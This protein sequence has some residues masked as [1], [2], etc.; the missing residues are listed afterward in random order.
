ML[1]TFK[2]GLISEVLAMLNQFVSGRL[3]TARIRPQHG[4]KIGGSEH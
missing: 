4:A 1:E 3:R 2:N